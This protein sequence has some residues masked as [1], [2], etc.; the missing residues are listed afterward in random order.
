MKNNSNKNIKEICELNKVFNIPAYQ[1]GYRWS[2]INV[3]Q[4]IQDIFTNIKGEENTYYLQPLLIR[5]YQDK[6]NVI[7]GQQRLTTI[8]LI[9]AVLK[10]LLWGQQGDISIQRFRIIYEARRGSKGFLDFLVD[11]LPNKDYFKEKDIVKAIWSDFTKIEK[12]K[13]TKQNLDFRYMVEAVIIIKENLEEIHRTR[14]ICYKEMASYLYE[15]CEFIWYMLTEEEI[16]GDKNAEEEQF[17]RINM[18]KIALSNAELI[19]AEFMRPK[20]EEDDEDYIHRTRRLSEG[21]HHIELSLRNP[22]FWAFIPHVDQYGIW[23]KEKSCFKERDICFPR[24]DE[25]FKMILV[26][27]RKDYE[28]VM[29]S[30]GYSKFFVYNYLQDWIS[31]EGSWEEVNEIF[32]NIKELYEADGRTTIY[33][34][35]EKNMDRKDVLY[36]LINYILY[37][38]DIVLDK[39]E[40]ISKKFLVDLLGKNRDERRDY[41][42]NK[43]K[44]TVCEVLG[45]VRWSKEELINKLKGLEYE[46]DSKSV[47]DRKSMH[48]DVNPKKDKNK[49]IK[50]ILLLFNLILL[51]N[52]PG[53][54]N[55]YDFLNYRYWTIEHIFSKNEH[56]FL[57]SQ[58]DIDS[59]DK[60][61]KKSLK[62]IAKQKKQL[63]N[64]KMKE[65]RLRI[66][67]N[68]A[69]KQNDIIT[70]KNKLV[71]AEEKLFNM[72]KE[73]IKSLITYF[74]NIDNEMVEQHHEENPNINYQKKIDGDYSQTIKEID[75]K[76][77]IKLIGKLIDD[78]EQ[79]NYP[80]VDCE[81]SKL[82]EES[83]VVQYKEEILKLIIKRQDTYYKSIENMFEALQEG[84]I[85]IDQL[86]DKLEKTFSLEELHLYKKIFFIIQPSQSQNEDRNDKSPDSQEEGTTLNVLKEI[87]KDAA[88][89]K[90]KTTKMLENQDILREI[91]KKEINKYFDEEHNR[92][93]QDN[94][95]KNLAL[96]RSVENRAIGNQFLRKKEVIHS[97][98]S[99]G[100]VI[101]YSTLLIF[102]DYYFNLSD[103]NNGERWQ[104]LPSSR[105]KYFNEMVNSIYQFMEEKK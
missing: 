38:Y 76:N 79:M 71:V 84:S 100:T 15:K 49:K 63:E 33:R 54:S 10:Y 99:E 20:E 37:T 23:D 92:L 104:W 69:K 91:Y 47:E 77:R 17:Y 43:V 87:I 26:K 78:V 4:L 74:D 1:R 60:E 40:Y 86:I 94:S 80:Q 95:V 22:D 65:D 30:D 32:Y 103:I 66:E 88:I 44:Q 68:I 61:I 28:E 55:R 82:I 25:L 7:D 8:L 72:R 45:I 24:I 21:W 64:V 34:Y 89:K 16:V 35:Y 81:W 5:E 83:I 97:Y 98:L 59:I 57:L 73:I 14:K 39:S 13:N 46:E 90:F 31:S 105:E 62:N 93:F 70:N 11:N 67:N 75:K 41:L 50:N 2:K 102:T 53:I 56:L 27:Q 96:L 9:I 101:P 29:K 42:K 51:E 3:K 19:K 18:G 12:Y 58:E 36:N 85:S 52:N 6:Y 48:R